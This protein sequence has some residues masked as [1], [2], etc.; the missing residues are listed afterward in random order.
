M[1]GGEKSGTRRSV[2]DLFEVGVLD[3]LHGHLRVFQLHR[4][5]NPGLSVRC[6]ETDQGLQRAGS[7][8]RGLMVEREDNNSYKKD[9]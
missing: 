9:L 8:W 2:A 1:F 7:H 3:E 6:G 5:A 4:F